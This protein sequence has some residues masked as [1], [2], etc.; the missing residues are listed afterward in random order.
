LTWPT[1]AD[2]QYYI[3]EGRVLIPIDPGTDVAQILLRPQGGLGVGIPAIAQGDPGTSPTIDTDITF[4]ELASSDSTPASAS[5]TETS[6]GVY[7]LTLSVHEGEPGDPG[8]NATIIDADDLTGTPVYKKIITVNSGATGFEYSTQ[9][10]GDRYIPASINNT[11]SGNS[12]FTLCSVAVPAQDFDWRPHVSGQC[13][14]TGTGADVKVD[15]IAR[16][17]NET[18]GN[19]VGRAF[20][21]GIGGVSP[22]T[23]VL[24]SGPPAGSADTY[25][26]VLAGDPATIYLRAERQSG[27][28]TFTTSASTTTFRVKVEPIL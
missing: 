20:A 28:D 7:K 12:L 22:P 16:L 25:D 18:S 3:F 10:V 11:P 19:I 23:H 4:T 8:S 15:L 27:G 2:G 26:K 21:G 17:N 24:V 5:W 9:R 6:P 13:V 14:I 1:T